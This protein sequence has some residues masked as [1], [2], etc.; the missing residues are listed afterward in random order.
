MH[1]L[2]LVNPVMR[3]THGKPRQVRAL[4]PKQHTKSKGTVSRAGS[5]NAC[6]REACLQTR[7]AKS[8]RS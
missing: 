5:S 7:R 4:E 8:V 2:L 3:W 6:C 1:P